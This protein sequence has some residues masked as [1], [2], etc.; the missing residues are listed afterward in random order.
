MGGIFKSIAYKFIPFIG[1]VRLN[2]EFQ[3]F[4]LLCFII[5][6]AI[7]L[8]NFFSS[9]NNFTGT[10]KYG[11]YFIEAILLVCIIAGLYYAIS[12]KLSV[13][14]EFHNIAQQ[15]SLPLALKVL[16]DAFS[17]YDTLWIQGII[18]LLI[19]WGIKWCL[20][21]GDLSLLQKIV[22]A[23]MIIASLLNVPFTGAGKGSVAMVQ[24]MINQSP[25]GIPIPFLQPINHIDTFPEQ[26]K[27]MIG[28]WSMYNKQIGVRSQV[29]YPVVL[30]NTTDYFENL[31]THPDNNFLQQAFVFIDTKK[32]GDT[33]IIKKFTLGELAV[34]V[35]AD[36]ASN[37]ILQ[38]NYYPHW[39]YNNGSIKKE[40][41]KAGINFMS[42]PLVK[43]KQII[44]FTFEP[45]LV[46][47]AM[48]LSLFV[49]VICCFLVL[50]YRFIKPSSPS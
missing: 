45:A 49:F 15:N 6:S 48:L 22:V 23:D 44:T 34:Q 25:K 1:Y 13:V 39:W 50:F 8:N 7:A 10:V 36:S 47:W 29:Y 32:D 35:T 17:F 37:L 31:S 24:V 3:I 21:N 2:G 30:K 19:L 18:Q 43:G 16:L 28:D 46:K 41:N 4:T 11:Y 27:E 9:K 12:S 5:V 20:K 33:I 38:Q 26:Q 40:T 14:H 42:A